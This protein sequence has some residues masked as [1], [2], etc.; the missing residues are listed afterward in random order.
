VG[1]LPEP[2]GEALHL[3]QLLGRRTFDLH[4]EL[5]SINDDRFRPVAFTRL[6]QRSLYQA[7]RSHT[8]ATY[9][10]VGRAR[11][12]IDPICLEALPDEAAVLARFASLTDHLVECDRIRVHGD[13]HLAQVLER[14][15]D[16]TFIDF[17]GEPARPLGERSIKRSGLV[18]VAGM[19]RSFDDVAHQGMRDAVDRG[20]GAENH[21]EP[22]A[23]RWGTWA[24]DAFVAAY[25]DDARGSDDERGATIAIPSGVTRLAPSDPADVA[26]LLDVFVLQKAL[27]EVVD[28]LDNRPRLA[29]IP[30][31]ALERVITAWQERP[32]HDLPIP[33]AAAAPAVDP[34]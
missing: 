20:V 10:A 22:F 13:L 9:A 8:R 15:G 27:S 6:Y 21:L 12:T 32:S 11:H 19:V 29:S 33:L 17:E 16:V 3:V 1:Q 26:M 14:G 23:V 5:A 34:L 30:I 2:L 31:R 24:A 18:D 4:R 7:M 25:L 28:E